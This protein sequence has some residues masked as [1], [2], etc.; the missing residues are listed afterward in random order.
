MTSSRTSA[1]AGPSISRST[2]S[3]I[4][5]NLFF[6][7]YER[8]NSFF[9]GTD[10][11]ASG[12]PDGQENAI[13]ES[14]KDKVPAEVFTTPYT[15]PVNDTDEHVRDNLREAVRLLGEAGYELKGGRLVSKTTGQPLDI[16]YL[17]YDPSLRALP[18]AL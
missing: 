4:N 6:G 11:A 1:C 3:S 13:L 15:N 5:R 7:R 18:R 16:E 8:T 14:L 17:G 9:H 10:L 2:S 12:L